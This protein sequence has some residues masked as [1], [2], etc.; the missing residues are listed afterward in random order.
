MEE[1]LAGYYDFGEEEG[2]FLQEVYEELPANGLSRYSGSVNQ[3]AGDD[4]SQDVPQN[5]GPSS[6]IW[7]QMMVWECL[8]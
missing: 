8:T 4:P 6:I 1:N 3:L 7:M 2:L 5:Q